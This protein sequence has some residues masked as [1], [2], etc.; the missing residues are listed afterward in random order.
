MICAATSRR[1][2]AL[3]EIELIC[4]TFDFMGAAWVVAW[5]SGGSDSVVNLWRIAS[6]SSAPWLGSED[7][8]NDP[9]DVKVQSNLRRFEAHA[10]GNDWTIDF[11][12]DNLPLHASLA[13]QVRCVD[14]HEDSVHAVAWSPA[15]PWIYCSLSF[16]GRYSSSNNSDCCSCYC[17]CYYTV[18]H[19]FFF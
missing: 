5:R 8:S 10:V 18:I 14:Q 1:S 15:D 6:C 11:N 17:R 19:A 2:G 9:P 12:M 4:V 16:D 13:A 3:W 7:N